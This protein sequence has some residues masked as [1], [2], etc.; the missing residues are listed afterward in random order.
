MANDNRCVFCGQ[1]LRG[2]RSISIYCAN[3][4]QNACRNCANELNRLD[5]TERCRR[6]LLLG[7]A[8]QPEL[9]R[10][11]I[12]LSTE[13]EAHRPKCLRCGGKLV[14]MQE[15][16]LDNTPHG[17]SVLSRYFEVLPAF[18]HTCG[19]YEFF[20]PATVRSNRYL[21]HLIDKDTWDHEK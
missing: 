2:F 18:C 10:E 1:S 5:N 7:L 13:A 14:F 17:S 8:D 16:H 4:T 21:K 11:R 12:E 15:Q 6:A 9:L 19:R 20:N 3:T